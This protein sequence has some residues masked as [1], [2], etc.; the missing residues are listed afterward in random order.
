VRFLLVNPWIADFAA[1]N[2]WIRPLGLYSLAQWLH[3][4]GADLC[5]LDCLSPFPAPGRFK[6]VPV[7]FDALK[8]LPVKR[9]FA[10][11]GIGVDEFRERL[12]KTKPFD[13]VFITSVMSYWYPGVKWVVEEIRRVAGRIPVVLGGIYPTLWREHALKHMDVDLVCSGTLE[14]N[15]TKIADFFGLGYKVRQWKPW[16]QLS[17]WDG[18]DYG[19]IRTAIGCPFRCTYCASRIVSG[20]FK[21]R[22][23]DQVL[24]ELL[25]FYKKGVR[26]IAF[27]DDALLVDFHNRLGPL[28]DRLESKGVSLQFHTPN[29]LH[30]KFL[31]KN[32]AQRLLQSDFRT[33]R[34]SLE[35]VDS[36]R[37]AST[38]GKVT[39]QDLERAVKNLVM[40]GM[41]RSRIGVYL[42]VGLPDQDLDE[43]EESIRYVRNLGVR[44]YLAEFS[45]IPGTMDWH[46]LESRNIVSKDMDPILTNNTIF[47]RLF[48]G[49][50]MER[51]R[52]LKRLA[53]SPV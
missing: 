40:A 42:L 20:S 51:F 15:R 35:T 4:M 16:Y 32:V 38:G 9:H 1:Y 44:P 33:I 39:S 14:K 53:A 6:R 31:S 25:F 18:V 48:S 28:L 21:Q 43:V 27:Y 52:R 13:G 8:D 41:K 19:A 29:G 17:L 26:Q 2:F 5:I 47:Y 12:K 23:L 7:Y 46:K 30:A 10:R 36:K 45:P 11:Y 37:Q 50:D 3:V 22:D 24:E 34:L 49:Y